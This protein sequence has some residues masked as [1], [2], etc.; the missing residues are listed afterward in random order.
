MSNCSAICPAFDFAEFVGTPVEAYPDISGTGVSTSYPIIP[1]VSRLIPRLLPTTKKKDHTMWQKTTDPAIKVL[2]GFTASAYLTL[3][4]VVVHYAMGC[5]PSQFLNGFDKGVLRT[6][7]RLARFRPSRLWEPPLR[8]AVLM[9][10]DQQLVTGIALLASGY[11][12]LSYGLSSYHWQL[13][14][15]LA[16]FSSLTHL[17]TLTALRYLKFLTLILPH[18]LRALGR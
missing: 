5:V 12:Q 14:V 18:S 13:I 10:S 17:T 6:V 11:S 3:L 8:N 7:W 2:A 15:Y 9:L 1:F 16:W 4:L